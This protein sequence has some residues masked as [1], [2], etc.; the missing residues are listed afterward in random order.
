MGFSTD[1]PL[2]NFMGFPTFKIC[3]L[4]E[5][6]RLLAFDILY[7]LFMKKI[8]FLA[9]RIALL[10]GSPTLDLLIHQKLRMMALWI[11]KAV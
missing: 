1:L 9:L 10:M 2:L 4:I 3:L 5:W 8:R 11:L 6:L 7:D